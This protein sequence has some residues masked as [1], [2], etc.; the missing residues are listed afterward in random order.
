MTNKYVDP[1][2]LDKISWSDFSVYNNFT[3]AE[4]NM[5]VILQAFI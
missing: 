4:F 2:L 1:E 3:I 5:S